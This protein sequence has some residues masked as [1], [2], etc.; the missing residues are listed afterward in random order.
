[1]GSPLGSISTAIATKKVTTCPTR[2]RIEDMVPSKTDV[3]HWRP[4]VRALALGPLG[5]GTCPCPGQSWPNCGCCKMWAFPWV[6]CRSLWPG[7]QRRR[8]RCVL[9]VLVDPAAPFSRRLMSPPAQNVAKHMRHT[10]VEANIMLPHHNNSLLSRSARWR[11]TGNFQDLELPP[12]TRG[13]G[14]SCWL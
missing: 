8:Q 2:R 7:G 14:S 4:V 9:L 1:M 3:C 11:W 6:R 12:T 5:P 10:T 13:G